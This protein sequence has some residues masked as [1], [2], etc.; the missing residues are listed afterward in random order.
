MY[1][2]SLYCFTEK[3]YAET[4]DY[5]ITPSTFLQF[6]ISMGCGTLY[7]TLYSVKLEYSIDTGKTW[8]SVIDECAPPKFICNGYHLSSQYVSEQHINWTRITIYLPAASMYVLI[9]CNITNYLNELLFCLNI[10]F[11][12]KTRKEKQL[13]NF[14]SDFLN[15]LISTYNHV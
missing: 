8:H 6:D 15:E 4:W 14:L 3:R 7:N 5:H 2:N 10:L 13:I 12:F 11:K 9:L 1:T